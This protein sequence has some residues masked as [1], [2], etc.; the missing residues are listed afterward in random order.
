MVGEGGV[1]VGLEG[2]EGR[3]GRRGVLVGLEEGRWGGGEEGMLVGRGSVCVCVR[4]RV[5]KSTSKTKR[6]RVCV[7][8]LV[9]AAES[10]PPTPN[11]PHTQTHMHEHKHSLSPPL[12][13]PPPATP[14]A[15][16]RRG[17]QSPSAWM[18]RPGRAHTPAGR[19]TRIHIKL[20]IYVIRSCL[21]LSTSRSVSTA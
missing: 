16:G 10:Q 17:R 8:G 13:L 15:P 5:S 18:C 3:W 9:L 4:A 2:E 12:D 6:A 1:L 14:L 20:N 7:T 11:P 19:Q 21:D